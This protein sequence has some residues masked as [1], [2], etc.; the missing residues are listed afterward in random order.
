MDITPILPTFIVT[1][2]E[3]FEAALVVGIILACLQKA[4]QT[5]LYPW[6]YLGIAIGILGSILIGFVLATTVNHLTTINDVYAPLIKQLLAT[7]FGFSA[8]V[9]LSWMLL[10]MNQQAKALK[11][12][13]ESSVNSAL[14]ENGA[15]KA[16]LIL[17]AIA[18]LREGFETVLFV[19]AKFQQQWTLPAI[20]AFLGLSTAVLLGWLL[21]AVGVKIN[22]KLFFKVM[23]SL[24]I[25]IVGGLVL[26][27]LFH[28]D[29]TLAIWSELSSQSLC[30]NVASSCI[31]GN[32]VWDGTAIL[33]DGRFPG[34]LLKALFGY[35][36]TLYAVQVIFYA[37]FLAFFGFILNREPKP[38]A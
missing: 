17:T 28:L 26:S 14:Q 23:S 8:I 33:P 10:W 36:Q 3:G 32:Q 22:L 38:K 1:L 12:E 18:V 6:V 37:V 27:C 4:K 21:F 20:G 29:K 2:R 19:L 34:I 35:R 15:A 25:L 24:L 9:M 30:L 31:L 11:G 13:I 16:V 7:I 5:K